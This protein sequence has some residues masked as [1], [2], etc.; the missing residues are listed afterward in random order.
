[1]LRKRFEFVQSFD[2]YSDYET[3]L[4]RVENGE[5]PYR[6]LTIV[7]DDPKWAYLTTADY[8]EKKIS[9][10]EAES[11]LQEEVTYVSSNQ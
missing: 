8:N 11:L 10:Q 4:D 1:M 2:Q 9:I 5:E 6:R 3:S 7:H